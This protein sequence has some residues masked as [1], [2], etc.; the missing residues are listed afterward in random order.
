MKKLPIGIQTFKEIIT[1]DYIYI[2]KTKEAYKLI[3]ARTKFYFLSRPRRFGK[4]LFLDT[5][6]NIFEGNR[7]LFKELYIYDKWNWEEKY[8]IIKIDFKG[9]LRSSQDVKDQIL[10][11]L[12]RNQKFLGIKCE[13]T[14]KYD[15]YFEELIEKSYEKYNTQVVILIDE[16][17]KAI[18][19]NLD[20]IEI[21]RETRE[22][23]KSLYSILKDNMYNPFD[24][25]LFIENNYIY[26]NYWFESW[27]PSFLIK[28]I[29]DNNYFLPKLSNLT[30][31]EKLLNSFDIDNIDL[32][33]ILYQSGYL[34]IDKR[35]IIKSLKSSNL[36][37]FKDAFISIFASISYNNY[38][39]NS[40][41]IYEGFYASIIYVYLQSLGV[42]IVGE[43]ITN[44]G[45]IDLTIKI[46]K[47]I[48]ILEFKVGDENALS[49]I[50]N[51]N[52]Y[53]KYLKE[54]KDISKFE[55]E[56]L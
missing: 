48:Y 9:N 31:D 41:Q 46:E 8:P 20:Q 19:D 54:E 17:D 51:R 37:D 26:K 6:A 40:I 52:Y 18:L 38:T 29:K 11:N 44:R 56:K 24:I 2:D 32:E 50:K 43:D 16:Y 14:T 33:V 34:T 10:V 49:Q 53:Q 21:A 55:W 30:V 47:I 25:L 7:E 3:E 5:L 4:S 1:K 22:I 45:R 13:N 15:I 39:K 28:L 35:D 36:E 23:V 42:D 12:K 27:T